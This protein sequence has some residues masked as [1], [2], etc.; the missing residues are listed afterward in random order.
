[1][2]VARESATVNAVSHV[3]T[4][5]LGRVLA[6]GALG[7]RLVLVTWQLGVSWRLQ[8]TCGGDVTCLPSRRRARFTAGIITQLTIIFPTAIIHLY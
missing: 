5:H 4:V 6:F 1:M 3:C 7:I 2:L 8:M